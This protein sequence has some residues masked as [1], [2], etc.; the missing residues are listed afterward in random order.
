MYIR[1]LRPLLKGI[2]PALLVDARM[3]KHA[4]PEVQRG[5]ADFTIGLGPELVAGRHAD[6]V[7]ET[8]WEGLESVIADGGTTAFMSGRRPR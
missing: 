4:T 1:S 3:E 2:A 7:V 6:V 8:S 5:L